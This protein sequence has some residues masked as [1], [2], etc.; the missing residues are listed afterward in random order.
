[1]S[2]HAASSR[3]DPE[4]EREAAEV[5]AFVRRSR[6]HLTADDMRIGLLVSFEHRGDVRVGKV[7]KWGQTGATV[8]SGYFV[9][10][11]EPD[12]SRRRLPQEYLVPYARL[13]SAAW[14]GATVA[15]RSGH[16]LLVQSVH[17]SEVEGIVTTKGYDGYGQPGSVR[18]SEIIAVHDD[19]ETW[20]PA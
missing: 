20:D 10:W 14:P 13:R 8:R 6:Q 17:G 11:D 1:V 18:V 5:A 7:A 4:L 15:T 2:R 16:T 9:R 12:P 3:R 19:G